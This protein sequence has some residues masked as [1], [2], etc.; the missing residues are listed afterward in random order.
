[1]K[2]LFVN[3]LL[4]ALILSASIA[5][6]EIPDLSQVKIITDHVG[7]NIYM[8]EATGD[9]A[10]NIA[11]SIGPDGILLVD[12]QFAPLSELILEALGKISDK[13]LKYII[14]THHHIDH[15]H[16]NPALGKYATIIAHANAYKRLT[17]M[18]AQ[19]QPAITFQDSASLFFNGEEIKIIHYPLGHTD[20]DVV[21]FFTKS[22]IVHLGDLWNSG[23]SSFPT[24]DLES[25]G[26]IIGM[27]RNV[28]SLI[29]IIPEDAKIIPG[30]YALSDLKAL[31]STR[32]MLLETIGIVSRKKASGKSLK[33]IQ[34]EGF[35]YEYD[36]WGTAYTDAKTWIE[37]IYLGL[38]Q[39]NPC[40]RPENLKQIQAKAEKS[41]LNEKGFWEAELKSGHFMVYIPAGEFTMGS[42]DGL[43][44]EKPVHKVYLDGY[45]ISKYPVTKGQ[46]EKFVEDADYVTDAEKGQG[47]WQYWK[48]EWIVRLDGNWKNTYFEQ[49][50]D[51]P[52]V[53]I[54]WNDA[55][56][57]CRWLSEKTGMD[58]TLPYAAQWEKGARGTDERCYPWGNEK[59]DGTR[60]NYADINFWKKYNNSRPADKNIDDG[61]TETSPVG[62]FPAGASPYGLLDMAGN[63][64]EW[65][66]DIF[67]DDYYSIS[68]YRNPSG[69]PDTGIKDQTR[70]NRG[71]G[72]WTDRSGHITPEGGHNLRSAARTGDEQ[73]S[74]DDHMG[75]RVAIDFAHY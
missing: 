61:Y 16:G 46:F 3:A 4:C 8:L 64:W 74:S 2:R 37:N 69:P 58:F 11:A 32:D 40:Q 14:N 22:N 66:Y 50:K 47:S 36:D 44:G 63:V 53:S 5:Q 59:P 28:E 48:G 24:V 72:S 17:A 12:T 62:S 19:G 6:E 42:N 1:M 65:C 71:G 35:P 20:N 27:L 18:P 33:Q 51:H 26:S 49:G 25:G 15:T 29:K 30:H 75:F 73:N 38:D 21:I 10:G 9:V 60:A 57:Y 55:M 54:S 13:P 52:A 45:W 34:K 7:G 23:I 68:A 56:A 43:S 67:Q 39:V 70:A 41:Y 31:Q